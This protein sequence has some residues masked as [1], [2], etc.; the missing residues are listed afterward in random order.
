MKVSKIEFNTGPFIA[1]V[2]VIHGQTDSP[3]KS[4]RHIFT[5]LKFIF[6]KAS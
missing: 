5:F 1:P 6:D 3:G 2:I 4:D